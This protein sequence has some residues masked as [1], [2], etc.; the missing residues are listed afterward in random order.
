VNNVAKEWRLISKKSF[1]VRLDVTGRRRWEA[2][3]R[4][5]W[6]RGV[7]LYLVRA[8][9]VLEWWQRTQTAQTARENV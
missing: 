6:D 1:K 4:R 3:R 2:S 9:L 5:A 8:V 7:V